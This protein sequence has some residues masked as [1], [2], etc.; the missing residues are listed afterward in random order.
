[1]DVI[2]QQ[3]VPLLGKEGDIVKVASGYA[4]NYL[5]PRRLAILATSGSLKQLEAKRASLA[6][7]ET[8]ARVEAE[9]LAKKIDGKSVVFEVRI[10]EEGKLYGSITSKDVAEAISVQLKTDVDK[11][12]IEL[13]EHIKEAGTYEV[14]VRFHPAVVGVL[15]VD[16]KAADQKNT[17]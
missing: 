2:L 13:A 6:K 16:V 3:E 15:K 1:M 17:E 8:M 4:N 11:R 9:N 12:R 5:L 10:G 7:K 14:K